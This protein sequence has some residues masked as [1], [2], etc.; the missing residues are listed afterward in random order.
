M[1]IGVGGWMV[2]SQE[3]KVRLRWSHRRWQEQRRWKGHL[4]T[5]GGRGWTVQ[6]QVAMESWSRES[7]STF[8][9]LPPT[10]YFLPPAT[11][12]LGSNVFLQ[13]QVG[14]AARRP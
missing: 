3:R 14:D 12:V 8:Y 2:V 13:V 7:A 4:F 11:G 1:E 5:S 9:L 6:F 10:S